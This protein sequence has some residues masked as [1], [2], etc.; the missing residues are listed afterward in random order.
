MIA[1]LTGRVARL[2]LDSLVLEVGGIGYLVR[3]TPQALGATRHG[4]ELTLHTELVVREDSLTLYGFPHAEEAE[5]FR[6][7]QSVSGIGPRTALAVLAV[8]DPE[9][10]RRAVAEQDT[11]T[12]TRTPGIGPKVAGRMLLELGGKLPAPSAPV[13]GTAPSA[14]AAPA[15]PDVDVVEALVGLGW[16]EKAALGAVESVRADGGEGLDA[17]ELLRRSLRGLGGHR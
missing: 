4:A 7:V 2:D 10:L 5:T 15:G 1:S 13:S 17:A 3:T 12:I 14:T 16:A 11:K 8:L 9:E 6:I